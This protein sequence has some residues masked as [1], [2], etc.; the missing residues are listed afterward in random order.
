MDGSSVTDN[1]IDVIDE[2]GISTEAIAS[3]QQSIKQKPKCPSSSAGFGDS[4]TIELQR[5][6]PNKERDDAQ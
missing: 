5:P 2:S 4:V 3:M 6:D 1:P